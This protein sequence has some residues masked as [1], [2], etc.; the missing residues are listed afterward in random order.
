ML[1]FPAS[2]NESML[3]TTIDRSVKLPPD[4]A[5]EFFAPSDCDWSNEAKLAST[6]GKSPAAGRLGRLTFEFQAGDTLNNNRRVYPGKIYGAAIEAL[7]PAIAKGQV[8]AKVDH[9]EQWD[10]EWRQVKLGNAAA[11]V[12]EAKMTGPKTV[13]VTLDV[14]NNQHG[15]QIASCMECGG[16][17]A[18]SQRGSAIWRDMSA[19]EKQAYGMPATDFGVIADGLRL[20]TFDVVAQPGFED[21]TD[22]MVT[23]NRG[24]HMNPANPAELASWKATNP[25]IAAAIALEATQ[26]AEATIKTKCDAAVEAAKPAIVAEAT[27]ALNDKLV[28]ANAS[29][30]EAKAALESL[31]PVL[32]KLG[33]VNEQITDKQAA[34]EVVTLKATVDSEKAAHESTK[35]LLKTATDKVAAMEAKESEHKVLGAVASKHKTH[36]RLPLI[37]DEVKRSK[38]ATEVAA[39]ESADR[40]VAIIG[41]VSKETPSAESKL[42]MEKLLSDYGIVAP[43]QG[44]QDG[45]G[46]KGNSGNENKGADSKGDKGT[47]ANEANADFK[48]GI[49]GGLA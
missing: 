35:T 20:F 9:P 31:K 40:I 47:K 13:K 18:V 21:A 36:P 28:A 25:A 15:Q 10:P 26:I 24:Q 44:S 2:A 19:A 48:A 39:I 14:L 42:A 45:S 29:A 1:R 27:K 30:T 5:M 22:P 33:I 6:S 34:V 38:P 11:R 8:W 41:D 4:A 32:V 49:L 17:V 46:G 37:L 43:N 7:Q 23:E 3:A 16:K 12:V